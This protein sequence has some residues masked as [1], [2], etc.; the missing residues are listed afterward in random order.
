MEV[1]T[2]KVRALE[3]QGKIDEALTFMNERSKS[4]LDVNQREDLFG[5]L[6]VS[7]GFSEKAIEHYEKLL[8]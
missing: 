8:E 5:R 2:L 1:L 4:F 3:K 7:K 6:Y